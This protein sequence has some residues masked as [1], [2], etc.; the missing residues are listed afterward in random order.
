[1]RLS[2][3]GVRALDELHSAAR[4]P[5]GR[6]PLYLFVTRSRTFS[7][8]SYK[9]SRG[10]NCAYLLMVPPRLRFE[11]LG[12]AA[13]GPDELFMAAGRTDRAVLQEQNRI[14]LTDRR[15]AV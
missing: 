3:S 6:S 4:I 8:T 11:Q 10:G 13:V 7:C 15:K 2:I 14:G 5:K 12:I 1:L 9:A